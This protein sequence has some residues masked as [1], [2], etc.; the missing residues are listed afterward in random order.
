MNRRLITIFTLV[1][2]CIG[3][4]CQAEKPEKAEKADELS[5]VRLKTNKGDIVIQLNAEKA[6]VTVANFKKYVAAGHYNGTVFHRVIENFM[7]QG[8][9]FAHEDGKLV[10]KKTGEGIVNEGQN[11]LKNEVGTIAMARTPDPNSATAQFFINV[12]DN[13]GLD[14]PSNGGYAVFGKVIEGMDV[15]DKIKAVK[16]GVK[17]LVSL[18]PRNGELIPGNSEDVPLELILIESATLE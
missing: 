18:H 10:E 9:G 6:P 13:K 16:T 15:V 12:A 17:E 11:G 14:F 8:G 5:K 2:L 3:S 1:A 4:S 7:I